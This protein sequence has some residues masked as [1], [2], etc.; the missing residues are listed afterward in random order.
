M[1]TGG[2]FKAHFGRVI[3]VM[4][5]RVCRTT[6]DCQHSERIAAAKADYVRYLQ[7]PTQPPRVFIH[8]YN[9]PEPPEGKYFFKIAQKKR[10]SSATNLPRPS[11]PDRKGRS[12]RH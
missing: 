8:N 7:A 12:P 1:V 2:I 9:N 10:R 4:S 3:L 5:S 11:I 6:T